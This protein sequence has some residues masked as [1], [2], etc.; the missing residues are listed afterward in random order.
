M[1]WN[2]FGKEFDGKSNHHEILVSIHLMKD[3]EGEVEGVGGEK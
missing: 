2:G 1:D 3:P